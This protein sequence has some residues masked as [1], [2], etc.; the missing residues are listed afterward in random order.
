MVLVRGKLEQGDDAVRLIASEIMPLDL[1][2]ELLAREVSIRVTL[3]AD[4]RVLRALEDVLARHR[5]DRRVCFE[6]ELAGEP[7]RLRVR[8]DASPRLRV[9]P[10]ST[11]VAEVEQVMGAGTVT[12]RRGEP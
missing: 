3:P 6:I 8:A 2:H 9:R 7:P 12:L 10:S 4:R 11:L 1:V 5:G